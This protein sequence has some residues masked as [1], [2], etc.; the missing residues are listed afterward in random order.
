MAFIVG[1]GGSEIGRQ[2]LRARCGVD[3]DGRREFLKAAAGVFVGGAVFGQ[4]RALAARPEGVNRPD[5]LPPTYTTVIV[6]RLFGLLGT[7]STGTLLLVCD[8]FCFFS[9]ILNGFLHQV[10]ALDWK[11]R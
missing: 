3:G 2:R 1:C 11:S 7:A 9:R 10:N 6:S 4:D 8:G 5:L